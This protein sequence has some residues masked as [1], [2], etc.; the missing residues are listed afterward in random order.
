MDPFALPLGLGTVLFGD[1][2]N[3]KDAHRQ[4]ELFTDAGGQL[5]DTAR[6]YGAWAANGQGYQ[7][8]V[9]Q[10]LGRW[11]KEPDHRRRVFV[12]T[13]GAHPLPESMG[14]MRVT[15]GAILSDL[16]QSLRNL[17]TD[18]IDL[19]LLHRDDISQPIEPLLETLEDAAKAGKLLQYGCSNWTLPRIQEAQA[20]AEAHGW[21]GFAAD[22][23]QWSLA[24]AN[25]EAIPDKT[26]VLMD[27]S[28]YDYHRSTGLP[29]MAYTSLAHGYLLRRATGVPV[30]DALHR[31]Y[32]NSANEAL[33][34]QIRRYHAD[35]L[36]LSLRYIVRQPFPA[37]P[38]AA[39][40][41]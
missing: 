38:L 15:P 5:V 26:L 28:L 10:V 2:I 1:R 19:Y 34:E 41:S 7:G 16:E 31:Q 39:F 36:A 9:E 35:P 14:Q 17:Q 22:Q 18:H 12:C 33:L 25:A 3:E 6:C 24:Q 23:V 29:L 30:S 20:I 37:V 4:L 8:M 13:K 27:Q 40:S 21:Q 32:D 11:L